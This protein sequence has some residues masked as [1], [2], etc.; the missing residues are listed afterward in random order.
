MRKNSIDTELRSH[1]SNERRQYRVCHRQP[2]KQYEVLTTKILEVFAV[3]M[4]YPCSLLPCE[5][6]QSSSHAALVDIR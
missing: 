5:L 3:E 4:S 1:C 6:M 2:V